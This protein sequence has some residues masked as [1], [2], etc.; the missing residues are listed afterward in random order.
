MTYNSY[1]RKDIVD[2]VTDWLWLVDESGV[3]DGPSREWPSFKSFYEKHCRGFDVVVQ[4][5]GALGMYPRLLSKMFK[6]VYT[7]EP[8]PRSFHFLVNNNQSDNVFKINAALGDVNRLVSLHRESEQNVGMNKIK[9][10]EGIPT[11]P[12]FT[13]DQ[14]SLDACNLIQLDIEGYETNALEGAFSTISEFKPVI[15][16]ENVNSICKDLLDMHGYIQVESHAA[17]T[18]FVPR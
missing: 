10:N 11:V 17:D 7:F 12:Q 14:L 4:A 8:D 3:W 13:I 18:I 6:R 15:Q 2:E 5:G 9:L 1:I 16:L